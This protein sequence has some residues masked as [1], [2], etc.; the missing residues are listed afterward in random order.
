MD[1]WPKTTSTLTRITFQCSVSTCSSM[2]LEPFLQLCPQ[3]ILGTWIITICP[4]LGFTNLVLSS[5]TKF[6]L[7]TFPC[8]QRMGSCTILGARS[9]C[10]IDELVPWTSRLMLSWVMPE[11]HN[12]K[13][14][15][16]PKST[17][18]QHSHQGFQWKHLSVPVSLRSLSSIHLVLEYCLWALA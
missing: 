7:T 8:T 14:L 13:D 18:R 4:V 2:T 3:A 10:S 9:W 12:H 16:S 1:S 6:M 11:F 5:R 15:H 17:L